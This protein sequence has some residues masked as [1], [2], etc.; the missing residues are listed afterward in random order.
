MITPFLEA[1]LVVLPRLVNRTKIGMDMRAA[2]WNFEATQLMASRSTTSSALHPTVLY[3]VKAKL[4]CPEIA[5]LFCRI[6][7]LFCHDSRANLSL[8]PVC[9]GIAI[10]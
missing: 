3:S 6:A 5:G 9:F 1:V 4:F 10:S 7:G 2:S 8:K